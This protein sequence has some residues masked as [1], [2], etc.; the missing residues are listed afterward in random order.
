M[1]TIELKI[2]GMTCGS[3]V[4]S[5]TEALKRVP[6]VQDVDVN[7]PSGMARVSGAHLGQQ[8]PELIGALSEAGYDAGVGA[9]RQERNPTGCGG[10][11]FAKARGGCCCS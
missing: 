1:Q 4:A 8:V 3:C 6:G 11:V 5:V 2:N 9:D 10:N 7:L